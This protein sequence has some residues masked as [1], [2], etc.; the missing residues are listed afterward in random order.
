MINSAKPQLPFSTELAN[1]RSKIIDASIVGHSTRARA[2]RLEAAG[3]MMQA[4]LKEESPLFE[5]AALLKKNHFEA[6]QN[7]VQEKANEW[8][9]AAYEEGYK[10]KNSIC[11]DK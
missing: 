3:A 10:A 9:L 5:Q 8:L 2:L 11:L 7:G 4:N 6:L 1:Y